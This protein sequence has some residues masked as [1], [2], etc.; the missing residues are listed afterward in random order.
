[1]SLRFRHI[2]IEGPIG[3]GKTSL[4]HKLASQINAQLLLEQPE[5]NP[6]LFRF[7]RD[8]ARYALQTQMHFLLQRVNQMADLAQLDLFNQ[9]IVTDFLLAK[10]TLFARLTLSPDE[11]RLYEQIYLALSPRAPSPDLV[12]YL[13]APS[14]VL[15]D[16][17]M[18]RGRLAEADMNEAYLRALID[19][20]VHF[21]HDYDEAPLLVVNTECLNPIDSDKDYALLLDRIEHMRGR[22]AYFN[23]AA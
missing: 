1:M 5:D 2:A 11:W 13:Q 23:L 14:N 9:H 12:I 10:D 3:V 6:F 7:Y 15:I 20:Y 17:V 21:F 16:R 18:R 8:P 22:R 4:A 19:S